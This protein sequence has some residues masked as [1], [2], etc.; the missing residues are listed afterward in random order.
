MHYRLIINR[1]PKRKLHLLPKRIRK[2]IGYKLYLM[3]EDLA[4]DIK[5]LKGSSNI[6]RLRVGD[7]R[8]IFELEGNTA[9][10]YDISDRKDAYR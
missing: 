6:Y 1:E 7:Y 10:V 8:V 4:G 9:T 3:Q 2:E 5:K